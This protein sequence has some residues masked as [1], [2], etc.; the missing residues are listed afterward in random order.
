[1][2]VFYHEGY[3]IIEMEAGPYLSA[4]YEAFRPQRHPYNEIVNLYGVPFEVG[5]LYY[6]SD[7]PMSK[8]HNLGAGSLSY[9][10]IDPTY[11]TA[12]AILHQIFGHETRRNGLRITANGAKVGKG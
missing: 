9:A 7:T 2:G 5:F 6:A 11:A 3:T 1:M 12:I 10:G 8:G 4:V